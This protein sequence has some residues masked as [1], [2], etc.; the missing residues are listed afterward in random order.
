MHSNGCKFGKAQTLSKD[1]SNLSFLF[2][3]FWCATLPLFPYEENTRKI[4]SR[5]VDKTLEKESTANVDQDL[6]LEIGT[7]KY[8][9]Y[10]TPHFLS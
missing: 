3:K 8:K 10:Q 5:L 7:N 9:G 1:S 4:H 6:S 2:L